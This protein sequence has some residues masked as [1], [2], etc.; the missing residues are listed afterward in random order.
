M[1]TDFTKKSKIPVTPLLHAIPSK[2]P[3]D[4]VTERFFF[5]IPLSKEQMEWLNTIIYQDE[6]FWINYWS[7]THTF[8]GIVYGIFYYLYPNIF[9]V[10]R[11]ILL[12]T[13]FELWELWG[14]GY[15]TGEHQLIYQEIV[16]IIMDTIF[17]LT[18]LYLMNYLLQKLKT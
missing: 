18:G 10:N 1:E 12:H 14:G 3:L 2:T 7:L 11:Y 13:F 16:D 5:L 17:G 4:L 9:T 8:L 6:I 15:L